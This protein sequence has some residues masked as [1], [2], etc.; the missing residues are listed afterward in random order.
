[1]PAYAAFPAPAVLHPSRHPRP[2]TGLPGASQ[3]SAHSVHCWMGGA[4]F[5]P[6]LPGVA[7]APLIGAIFSFK[8]RLQKAPPKNAQIFS[9]IFPNFS[10]FFRNIFFGRKSFESRSKVA[11]KV[12]KVAP[13]S[14]RTSGGILKVVCGQSRKSICESRKMLRESRCLIR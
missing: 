3:S 11:A 9:Q 14:R 1:M 6:A 7:E 12:A 13:E 4:A 5:A 8:K 10:K 2:M